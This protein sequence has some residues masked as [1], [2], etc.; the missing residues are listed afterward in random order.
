MGH[1]FFTTSNRRGRG[2]LSLLT[3]EELMVYIA[4]VTLIFIHNVYI[5]QLNF[6]NVI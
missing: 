2:A 4:F 6:R 5:L 1:I 3:S